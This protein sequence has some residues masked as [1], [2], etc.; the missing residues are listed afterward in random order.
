M[1]FVDNAVNPDTGTIRGRAVLP[2]PDGV[3][4]PGLFARVRLL[5]SAPVDV[6]LIHEQALLTDQDRRYVYVLGE[7][8]VTLRKDVTLGPTIEGL[9]V[10]RS[11]LSPGDKIVDNGVRKIFYPGQKVNPRV[12]PM[13]QP[14]QPA[15]AAPPAMTPAT[16]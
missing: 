7:D 12:V 13:D 6:M 11:G 16:G 9:R 1:D 8:G 15:P 3:F 5:G 2:N 10:V 4:T 14:N